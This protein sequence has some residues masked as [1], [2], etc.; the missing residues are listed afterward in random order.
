MKSF[1]I[2]KQTN[3]EKKRWPNR[4]KNVKINLTITKLLYRSSSSSHIIKIYFS[5]E[6]WQNFSSSSTFFCFDDNLLFQIHLNCFAVAV[7]L[8]CFLFLFLLVMI[9][10]QLIIVIIIIIIIIFLLIRCCYCQWKERIPLRR[11]IFLLLNFLFFGFIIAT[12]SVCVCVCVGERERRR[13][14]IRWKMWKNKWTRNR[15]KT[16]TIFNVFVFV[17]CI[18]KKMGVWV[19]T[20]RS[21]WW[22]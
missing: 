6:F 5:N 7:V 14:R 13:K 17:G 18:I 9:N 16:P 10:T 21:T 20:N 12:N 8:L 3:K 2:N 1:L 15:K 19:C 22:C 11:N 4:K